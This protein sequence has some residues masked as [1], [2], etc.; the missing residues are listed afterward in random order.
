MELKTINESDGSWYK[1]EVNNDGEPHG[2]GVDAWSNGRRYVGEFR[3]GKWYGSGVD[4]WPEGDCY[5]YTSCRFPPNGLES[6][7]AHTSPDGRFYVGEFRYGKLH[8][9]GVMTWPDSTCFVGKFCD[10]V[11]AEGVMTEP[12]G[13]MSPL[14]KGKWDGQGAYVWPNGARYVGSIRDGKPNGQG[15]VTYLRGERCEGEFCD[16]TLVAPVTE[17]GR[18]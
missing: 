11:P 17:A 2:Y 1:G 8:G 3:Y 9:Q 13:T 5:V 10:G 6:R 4:T 15:V 12:D 14:H 7:G 18:D 16:G